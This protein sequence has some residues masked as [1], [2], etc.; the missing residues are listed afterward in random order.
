MGSR[1]NATTL[2][3]FHLVWAFVFKQ[4]LKDG[5][6]AAVRYF[7]EEYFFRLTVQEAAEQYGLQD[8]QECA[9]GIWCAAW[10]GSYARLQPGS[11]CGSQPVEAPHRHGVRARLVDER[12]G[13]L[14]HLEPPAFFKAFRE[15][16]IAMSRQEQIASVE[17]PD[18]PQGD[19]AFSRSSPN[20]DGIGR[21]NAAK[22]HA[23]R[24]LLHRVPLPGSS[25]AWVLPQSLLRWDADREMYSSVS[26]ERLRISA[27][28]ASDCVSMATS[29][30]C[31]EL[32]DMWRRRGILAGRRNAL[33]LDLKQWRRWRFYRV[34]VVQGP[35]AEQAWRC[36]GCDLLLCSCTAFALS[37]RCEHEQCVLENG[38]AVVGRRG[39]GR[40]A[41]PAQ[42]MRGSPSAAVFAGSRM[43]PAESHEGAVNP[44]VGTASS[45]DA[46]I[47]PGAVPGAASPRA[48]GGGHLGAVHSI[49]EPA[50]DFSLVAQVLEGRSLPAGCSIYYNR[51]NGAW[52]VYRDG[53]YIRSASVR[54]WGSDELAIKFCASCVGVN[55]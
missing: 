46:R 39:R 21:S 26:E 8:A 42:F 28:E 47:L 12:G 54:K 11:A 33:A 4:L 48:G 17:L 51:Q 30:S 35:L 13:Q 29:K 10:W 38:L 16:M 15:A 52:A 55:A 32:I 45:S 6:R 2:S 3:E 53:K 43:C 1:T 7:R 31:T 20:M 23:R 9:D 44:G 24:D 49:H 40:P 22:L 37:G 36:S 27:D 50:T 19:D 41:K 34:V 5:E 25:C 18:R 14:H